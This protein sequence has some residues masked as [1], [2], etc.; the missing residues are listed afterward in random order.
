MFCIVSNNNTYTTLANTT[1]LMDGNQVGTY[2]HI[3]TGEGNFLYNVPVYAETGLANSPHVLTMEAT[4][5]NASLIL[6]DYAV[7]T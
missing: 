1:F 2:L 4:G 5:A 6:F 7:Y 3:P